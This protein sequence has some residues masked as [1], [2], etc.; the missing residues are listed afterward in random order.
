MIAPDERSPIA[1]QPEV[2]S[3]PVDKN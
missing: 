1:E 2:E 3:K